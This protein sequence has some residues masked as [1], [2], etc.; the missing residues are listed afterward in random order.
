MI[1]VFSAAARTASAWYLVKWNC[2]R[3]LRVS[4]SQR[5][6]RRS[7]LLFV[8]VQRGQ[9]VG[10]RHS[11]FFFL[12]GGQPALNHVMKKGYPASDARVAIGLFI[13]G[14]PALANQRRESLHVLRQKHGIVQQ[15]L[16][17]LVA[18]DFL[19]LFFA[20]RALG[21]HPFG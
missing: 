20:P 9:I 12:E 19:V 6:L 5:R 1:G 18:E 17:A 21:E 14:E 16:M 15:Q 2:A 4:S 13:L 7:Q 8:L 11:R 3:Y 10:R